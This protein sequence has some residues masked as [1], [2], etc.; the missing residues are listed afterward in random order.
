LRLHRT[1]NFADRGAEDNLVKLR[2]HLSRAEL[3]EFAAT[4]SGG[5]LRVLSC[6]IGEI[7][8]LIYLVFE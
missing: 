2:N 1:L 4:L 7:R 3:T 6:K 5:T 8:A